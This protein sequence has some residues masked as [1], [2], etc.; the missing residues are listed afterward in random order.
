MTPDPPSHPS[1][2]RSYSIG[3]TSSAAASLSSDSIGPLPLDPSRGR[4]FLD[5]FNRRVLLHGANVS[6]VSKLPLK[7]NAETHVDLGERWY[8][9]EDVSFVGR[10]WPLEESHVHLAR[11]RNWGLSCVRLV[12]PWEAVEHGGPGTYDEAYLAYLDHLVAL[13]P[14]YGLKCYI[15]AHQDVWSRHSGGSGAPTWTLQLVGLDVRALKPTGAAHAHNLHLDRD[16]DPPPKVW[17]AGMTKLAA[18]TMATVFWGGDIFCPRRKVRRALHRGEYGRGAKGDDEL[19]GLQEFLQRSMVEAFGVVADR[20]RHHE[21]VVGFEVINE[22]HRGYISLH[23]P[24]QWDLTADLAIGYFPSALQGWALGNGHAVRISHYVESF[25]VTKPSH[26][27]VLRPPAGESAWLKPVDNPS[28]RAPSPTEAIRHLRAETSG[29]LWEE[30]GVWRWDPAKQ[31][32]VVLKMEYFRR[33]DRDLVIEGCRE[34]EGGKGGRKGRR[35]QGEEVVWERDCYFPFVKMFGDR[36]TRGENPKHWMTFVEPIPNEF[37]PEY[38]VEARPTNMV[39]SPHWYDLQALFEKRLGWMSANVQGLARGMFLLKALYFGRSGL[40]KNY[41]TQISNIL[42]EAY[43]KIGERPVV[44]GETGCPFD[45]NGGPDRVRRV[46]RGDWTGSM[47]ERMVDAILRAIGEEGLANYNLWNYNPLNTDEWGDSWNGENFSWFSSSDVTEARLADASRRAVERGDDEGMARLNVG[48]RVLDAVERPYAVKTAGIPLRT[49]YDFHS[50][51]FSL[52]Y[53]NPVPPDSPVAAAVP[54]P[55]RPTASRPPIVGVECR[56]RETEVYLPK[57]R[58]AKW[59]REGKVVVKM[60]EG[61]GEWKWDEDLQTLYVLHTN[62]MPG[63]VHTLD[64]SVSLA[65]PSGS[66]DRPPLHE[67]YEPRVPQFL[68]RF[69]VDLFAGDWVWLWALV[70]AVVGIRMG[71]WLVVGP[72]WTGGAAVT[73]DRLDDLVVDFGL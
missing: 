17:P 49:S 8:D 2:S 69:N 3:S 1:V 35:K 37:A 27:V 12:V 52:A 73:P 68:A 45:L 60:R 36:M 67:W 32:P 29:C 34:I 66:P 33:F 26:D 61:D 19:V 43:D 47:Q 39:F 13:F 63:F 53:I 20:L 30:H 5:S 59:F 24:H 44:V 51:R 11:L 48:A 31:E 72:G 41:A 6:G 58:Y 70:I 54:S 22:P 55:L 25:P 65:S 7:P 42:T 57:R 14:T 23:S 15:D 40:R 18:A 28:Y 46:R 62:L 64:V 71:W 9:G 56:A 4:Y 50:L 16:K 21:A 10:P 38:P